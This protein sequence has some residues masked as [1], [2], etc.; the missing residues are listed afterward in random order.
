MEIGDRRRGLQHVWALVSLAGKKEVANCSPH[1]FW[2][3]KSHPGCLFLG[4]SEDTLMGQQ[5]VK[6][7]LISTTS[8]PKGRAPHSLRPS[9]CSGKQSLFWD[10]SWQQQMD[11][12]QK[13]LSP[14]MALTWLP[15]FICGLSDPCPTLLHSPGTLV[16]MEGLTPGLV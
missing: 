7:N 8:P 15:V 14:G 12:K 9:L 4:V 2:G 10:R 6:T 13:S 1:G 3:A 16:V 5:L 11:R